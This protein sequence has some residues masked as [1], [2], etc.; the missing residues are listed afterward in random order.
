MK[1]TIRYELRYWDKVDESWVHYDNDGDPS[2]LNSMKEAF[3]IAITSD[4]DDDCNK[5]CPG[6][7]LAKVEET[8]IKEAMFYDD[9]T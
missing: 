2:D 7:R 3:N 4:R 5:D 8:I 9:E 1:P 6:Y